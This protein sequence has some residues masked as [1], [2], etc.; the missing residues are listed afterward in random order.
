MTHDR[1]NTRL[2]EELAQHVT[3]MVGGKFETPSEYIRHLIRQDI[4]DTEEKMVRAAIQEG[5]SDLH[6][7]QTVLSTGSW[8]KDLEQA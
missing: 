5:L 7:G 3:K 6:K 4:E 2:P 1:I 8:D